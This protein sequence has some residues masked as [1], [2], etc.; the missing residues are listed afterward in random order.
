VTR[1]RGRVTLSKMSMPSISAGLRVKLDRYRER[2][3]ERLVDLRLF[4]SY[5]RG[6]AGPDSDVDVLVL[7]RDP[8]WREIGEAIEFTVDADGVEPPL[9]SAKVFPDAHH[10]RMVEREQPF[11]AA[12]A[13]EG[14]AL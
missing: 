4:G 13:R 9:L 8:T 14:I 3:G 7:L 2:F 10:R 12:V 5:A 1:R 11:H 6:D